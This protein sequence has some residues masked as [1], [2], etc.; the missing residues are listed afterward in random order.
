MQV[1]EVSRGWRCDQENFL[2]DLADQWFHV[3]FFVSHHCIMLLYLSVSLY[4]H[5]LFRSIIYFSLLY[6]ILSLSVSHHCICRTT[7]CVYFSLLTKGAG[8]VQW[9]ERGTCD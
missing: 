8:I 9:L 5:T 4:Y 1:Q 2:T 6:H 7:V 3:A